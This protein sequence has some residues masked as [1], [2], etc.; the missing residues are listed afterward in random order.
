MTISNESDFKAA[1]NNLSRAGQRQ[2]GARFVEDVLD[3]SQDPRLKSAINSAKR[4]DITEDELAAAS[5]SAQAA[6]VDSYTQCGHECDWN[7]Q[8][9]HFVAQAALACLKPAAPGSNTA[10]DAAM[11]ARMARTCANIASGSGTSNEEDAAQYRILTEFLN[12]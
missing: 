9:G 5:R 3:C 2:A 12:I 8:A 4:G 10:W 6:S 1:L 11:H 7:S